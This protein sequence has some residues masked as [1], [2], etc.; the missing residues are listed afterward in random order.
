MA[1]RSAKVYRYNRGRSREGD[2]DMRQVQEEF[3][4]EKQT[5][6]EHDSRLIVN[7]RCGG[8]NGMGDFTTDSSRTY[9]VF[10][11]FYSSEIRMAI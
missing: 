1:Y 5:R 9:Y 8:S 10:I 7:T 6:S 3:E 4:K 2:H 11:H